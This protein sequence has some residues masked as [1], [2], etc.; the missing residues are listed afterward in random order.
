[1]KLDFDTN[2]LSRHTERLRISEVS[3]APLVLIVEDDQWIQNIT[4]ELLED[5]GFDVASATDGDA[6]LRLAE[7]LLPSVVLLDIG[8]PRIGPRNSSSD[9]ARARHCGTRR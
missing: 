2:A 9:F 1:M 3:S 8:L 4:R 5:E 6:G 7:R